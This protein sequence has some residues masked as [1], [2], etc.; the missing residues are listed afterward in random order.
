MGESRVEDIVNLVSNS[1][2]CL[3]LELEFELGVDNFVEETRQEQPS[4][5][6]VHEEPDEGAEVVLKEAE[7]GRQD[8]PEEGIIADIRE[9]KVEVKS[10]CYFVEDKKLEEKEEQKL[11]LDVQA[12]AQ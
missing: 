7:E 9:V 10:A 3:D 12:R 1:S 11:P 2:F 6:Q 4:H 8:A 5:Q